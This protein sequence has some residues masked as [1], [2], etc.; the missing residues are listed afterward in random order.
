M[1][2]LL[3]GRDAAF[4][5]LVLGRLMASLDTNVVVAALPSI[6]ADLGDPGSVGGVT[7]AYLLA[8][9]VATPVHGSLGD[10]W[11]RRRM[12]VGSVTAFAVGSVACALAP[13]LAALIGFR[14]V[15]GLGGGGLIVA[16]VAAM[17]ELFD[18]D[19]LVRR[20]GWLTAVFALSSIGGA[21]L[22]GLLAAVA[23]WWSIFLINL[24]ICVVALFLGARSVPGFRRVDRIR[25]DSAGAVLVAIAGG[26]VVV[27]GSGEALARDAVWAPVLVVAALAA[28]GAFVQVERRT[29]APLVP[30][31]LFADAGLAR[32]VAVTFLTGVALFGSFTYVPLVIGAARPEATALLLVPMSVGQVLVTGGFALLARR[33]SRVSAWGR[34]GL[35]LG[36]VGLL[37]TAAIPLLAPGPARFAAVVVGLASSGAALGLSMQ[38]YTLLA[39]SSA[40]K[41]IL[42]AGLATLTFARQIGGSLGIAVFSLLAL[43]VVFLVAAAAMLVAV[44]VA[45]RRAHDR[46]SPRSLDRR[47]SAA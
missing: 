11:G 40:P 18:R 22:G 42:G 35:A 12:F 4:A 47:K 3:R 7:A 13:N 45:P 29:A 26:C 5:A 34:F 46:L 30:P 8:V 23:G 6:G 10:R 43:P 17:A 20:Q 15:Q 32:V 44:V 14:A 31:R 21:P 36:V 33:W 28:T 27:L 16:A 24:P 41:D 38:A 9:A 37:V 25:F 1:H 2:V 39:Q 19:E